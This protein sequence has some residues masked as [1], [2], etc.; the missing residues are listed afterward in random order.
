MHTI[1]QVTV[2]LS[3]I[4]DNAPV[5]DNSSVTSATLSESST[6]TL[7]VATFTVSD[8]DLIPTFFFTL[9]DDGGPFTISSSGNTGW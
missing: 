2:T 5:F 9:A 4:N 1:F 3:D 8:Q 7:F 6:G